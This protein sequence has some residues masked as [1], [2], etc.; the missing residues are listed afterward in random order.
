MSLLA[1]T[2]EE[3]AAQAHLEMHWSQQPLTLLSA[4]HTPLFSWPETHSQALLNL[5][6]Q[7]LRHNFAEWFMVTFTS[8]MPL[9]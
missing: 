2:A 8:C 4:M 5:A 3:N 1:K 7:M 6:S 9:Q